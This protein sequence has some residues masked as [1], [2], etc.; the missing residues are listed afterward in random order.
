MFADRLESARQALAAGN[1]DQAVLIVGGALVEARLRAGRGDHDALAWAMVLTGELDDLTEDVLPPA[2]RTGPW[3][4]L[5]LLAKRAGARPAE[6]GAALRLAALHVRADRADAAARDAELVLDLLPHN[7]CV[8][9]DGFEVAGPRP[10][11]VHDV[12][13]AVADLLHHRHGKLVETEAL[14]HRMAE[15]F[16]DAPT[17]WHLLGHAAARQEH[18]EEAARAFTRLTELAPG[19]GALMDLG[20]ALHA[21]GRVDEALAVVGD[22]IARRPDD[23]HYR[24]A[25]ARLLIAAGRPD[26][27]L[28]DL[29]AVVEHAGAARDLADH[30]R[31]TRLH[32]LLDAGRAA[33]ARTAALAVA[34]TADPPAAGAAHAVLGEIAFAEGD[35]TAAAHHFGA[36]LDRHASAS[37]RLARAAAFEAAGRLD[38]AIADLDALATRDGDAEAA[39]RALTR[40]AD[41]HPGHAAVRAALG[42]A[43]PAARR[44]GTA[45]PVPD[46]PGPDAHF[47][48]AYAEAVAMALAEDHHTAALELV[49]RFRA[50]R[51]VAGGEP[52]S[53]LSGAE[54]HA[55]LAED[56]HCVLA[57]FFVAEDRTLLFVM[58]PDDPVPEVYA[59]DL[60][61]ADLADLVG[62]F[63][64]GP[65]RA[66]D[67]VGFAEAF[68]ALVEPIAEHCA[69]GDVVLLVPHGPLHRVPLHALMSAR[70]PVCHVPSASSLR[71]RRQAPDR[72]WRSAVVFGDPH[73]DHTHA[74]YEAGLVAALFGARPAV[75]AAASREGL[76]AA[77]A[78][79]GPDLVH[80]ACRGRFAD[81]RELGA[82]DLDRLGPVANLVTLSAT[83]AGD[84]S[85]GLVRAVLHAGVPS[86]VMSLWVVDHLSTALLMTDFYARV[87]GG[88]DLAVALRDAQSALAATTARGVVAYCEARLAHADDPVAV[89][90]LLLD[91]AGAEAGAGDVAAALVTCGE[92]GP[93]LAGARG[94]PARRL[95]SRAARLRAA[96]VVKAESVPPV[97]YAARPF[98]HPYHWAAFVLVGDWR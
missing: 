18:H 4:A 90:G 14:A 44:P 38:D 43:L 80:L 54:I 45:D 86:L 24:Y 65:V 88:A 62:R 84:E 35:F 68:G 69:P 83:R 71:C 28:A 82:D 46:T 59:W 57:E 74:R 16:P 23:L 25:R 27:A 66:M 93:V 5:R 61:A 81:G 31:I 70:N 13:A 78:G 21:L 48:A 30:A 47:Q 76:L 29:D 12:L 8:R 9:G 60:A 79:P 2:E 42:H 15:A 58:T 72:R 33:E 49:E 55:L 63:F 6:L 39:V 85:T 98:A 36:Q 50:S 1:H 34:A 77:V 67:D 32:V 64:D 19:P 92:V 7:G 53:T 75:G 40:L 96:L 10:D 91:R 3:E 22:A 89:A 95:R 17:A 37:A 26:A 97:D 51:R 41:R 11:A 52:V 73:D 56:G 87:R 94:D 20:R